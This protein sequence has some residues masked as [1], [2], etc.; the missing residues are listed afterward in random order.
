MGDF[1][2]SKLSESMEK[3]TILTWIIGDGYPVA[4]GD[5]IVEKETDKTTVTH[6]S[7]VDG[8]LHNVM[9][10][11]SGCDVGAVIAHIGESAN[12]TGNIGGLLETPLQLFL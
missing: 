8:I 10:E 5:E 3:S 1:L 12:Q 4:Q 2:M 7:D 6:M 9:P 11:G